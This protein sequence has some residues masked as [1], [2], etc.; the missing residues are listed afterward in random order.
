MVENTLNQIINKKK[1]KLSELKKIISI[2]SLKDKIEENK[3]FIN[4]KKKLKRI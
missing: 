4:F 2:E 3:N 1:E